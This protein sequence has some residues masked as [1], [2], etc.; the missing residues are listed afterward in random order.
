VVYEYKHR[1][2]YLNQGFHRLFLLCILF[3]NIIIGRTTGGFQF[4]LKFQISLARFQCL[5]CGACCTGDPGAVFVAGP[6]IE[7][8]AEFFSLPVPDFIRKYLYPYKDSYSIDED[9]SGRCLFYEGKCRIYPVRPLQCR[10]FPFWFN[11]LRAEKKWRQIEKECPGIGKGKVFTKDEILEILWHSSVP[12]SH[13][14][15]ACETK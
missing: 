4:F 12:L 6:E 13:D 9:D 7:K 8:I 10:T 5:Q 2:K 1:R 11:Y 15:I 3:A 14:G